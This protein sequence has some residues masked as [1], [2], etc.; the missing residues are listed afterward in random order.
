[1]GALCFEYLPVRY[2]H[3]TYA[4]HIVSTLSSY[5]NVK[6]L[7]ARNR[8]NILKIKGSKGIRTHSHLLCNQ[9]L[10]HLTKL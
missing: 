5:L 4:F 3:V 9:T 6:K 1:M 10:N 7:H 8:C 2:H